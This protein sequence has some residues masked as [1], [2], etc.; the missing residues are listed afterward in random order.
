MDGVGDILLLVGLHPWNEGAKGVI[1]YCF[2]WELIPVWSRG[3]CSIERMSKIKSSL[4]P[5]DSDPIT[6]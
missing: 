1:L 3:D 4:K 5:A 2:W 6:S